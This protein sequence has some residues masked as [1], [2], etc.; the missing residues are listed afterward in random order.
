MRKKSYAPPA[1]KKEPRNQ[2]NP[3]TVTREGEIV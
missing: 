1:E 2:R 3:K